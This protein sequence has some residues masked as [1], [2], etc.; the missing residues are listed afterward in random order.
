MENIVQPGRPQMTVWRMRIACRIPKV[1]MVARTRLLSCN[2]DG[3]F[4]ASYELDFYNIF[5]FNR[6][7][8]STACRSGGG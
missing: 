1:T 8:E 5:Q 4:T 2:R 7:D 3:A 6:C